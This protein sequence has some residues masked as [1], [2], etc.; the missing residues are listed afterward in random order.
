MHREP[1]QNLFHRMPRR[2]SQS[3]KVPMSFPAFEKTCMPQPSHEFYRQRAAP[4]GG[5]A[6]NSYFVIRIINHTLHMNTAQLSNGTEVVLNWL[7]DADTS[8]TELESLD[9]PV[10]PAV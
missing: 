4:E 10:N 5:C 1:I 2:T 3:S 8:N 7:K 9:I 6:V